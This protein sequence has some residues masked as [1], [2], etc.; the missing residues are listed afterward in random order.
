[1]GNTSEKGPREFELKH[2]SYL[3]HGET[4]SQGSGI[5]AK[6]TSSQETASKSTTTHQQNNVCLKRRSAQVLKPEPQ[7]PNITGRW[8]A[9]NPPL[10]IN[11]PSILRTIAINQA[12]N[13]IEC[14]AVIAIG[15]LQKIDIFDFSGDRDKANLNKFSLSKLNESGFTGTIEV[16]GQQP[17]VTIKFPSK[18]IDI[19]QQRIIL[20]D[21]RAT[22]SEEAIAELPPDKNRKRLRLEELFPLDRDQL[23]FLHEELDVKKIGPKIQAYLKA[24]GVGGSPGQARQIGTSNDVADHI[25]NVFSEFK[26]QKWPPIQIPLVQSMGRGILAR[27]ELTNQKSDVTASLMFW[28]QEMLITQNNAGRLNGKLIKMQRHLQLTLPKS[29]DFFTYE[30]E[31]TIT[32]ASGKLAVGIGGFFGDFKITQKDSS[33]NERPYKNLFIVLGKVSGGAKIGA[34]LTLKTVMK[35]KGKSHHN[36]DRRDFIGFLWLVDATAKAGIGP[37]GASAGATG[38]LIGNGTKPDLMITF[39]QI[40][41]AVKGPVES[42]KVGFNWGADLGV[43]LGYL[44]GSKP[45]ITKS[46]KS[47]KKSSQIKKIP[48]T[49]KGKVFFCLGDAWLTE[50]AIQLIRIFCAKELVALSSEGSR[51]TI[52]GHADRVDTE[53]NN[54]ELTRLR[55]SNAYEVLKNILG[56]SLKIFPPQSPPLPENQ[57]EKGT[58]INGLG[59]RDAKDAGDK[60]GTKNPNFRK[61]EIIINTRLAVEMFSNDKKP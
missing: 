31:A 13:H 32:S 22:L 47:S 56:N 2:S 9:I 7:Q 50:E 14:W 20:N 35:G 1:M 41:T 53:P 33:G 46:D 37:V 16:K 19:S 10:F 4:S 6:D 42:S 44:V 24:L 36:Y 57:R 43:G 25:D 60:D 45:P 8:E 11:A 52:N 23:N 26:Q 38:M 39:S 21:K 49:L 48:A 12:G 28:L 30:V 51:L 58:F 40:G 54:D 27:Q 61:V 5:R 55:A 59:E 29:K 15:S 17:F 3:P 34:G 18:Q